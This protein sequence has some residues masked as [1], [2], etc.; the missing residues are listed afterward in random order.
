MFFLFFL[1][2]AFTPTVYIHVFS[3]VRRSLLYKI[4]VFFSPKLGHPPAP[5]LLVFDRSTLLLHGI[6]VSYCILMK[7]GLTSKFFENQE[8]TPIFMLT[9]GMDFSSFFV[10][11]V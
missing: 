8:K 1:I 10:L 4:D 5:T 9:E 2:S 3:H 7:S 11:Q 6:Y